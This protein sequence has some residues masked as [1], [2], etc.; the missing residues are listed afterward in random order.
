[1]VGVMAAPR[2][3]T[4]PEHAAG[5]GTLLGVWAHPDDE[6]YL[7]AGLMALVRAAGGR[8]VCVTAT[9]GEHGTPDP[10]R[11]PPHRL[12]RTRELEAAAAM[13]VL[14]VDDHRWLGMEDGTLADVDHAAGVA[15]VRR[16]LDEVR[17][18]TI[19]TFG[20]DGMTGHPDHR[21]VSG[22]VTEAWRRAGAGPRL[23]HATTT[24]S[25]ADGFAGLHERLGVFPPG[26]PVRTPDHEV[27][28]AVALD[29]HLLDVKLA[30]L[31][32]Q[33]TQVAPLVEIAGEELF[34]RWWGRETFVAAAV[35]PHER[36]ARAAVQAPSVWV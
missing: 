29:D 33:A 31:R 30:A 25:F 22:W 5:L 24:A 21:A 23:L 1:M 3:V 8:V 20:P 27:D 13:A 11:W 32:A 6:T 14:G 36:A 34:R 15:V 26:L 17:P 10:R 18:D 19:V 7:S 9:R 2:D 16:L 35:A 4:T 28:L 12:A